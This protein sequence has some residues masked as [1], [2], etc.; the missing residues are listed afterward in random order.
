MAVAAAGRAALAL[1]ALAFYLAGYAVTNLGAF[2]V[3]AEL[4]RARTLADY[5]GMATRHRWLALSLIICLLGLIGTPPTA[6]FVGKLTVFTAAVDA[7]LAWLAVVAVVQR[8][9]RRGGL[10]T[11]RRALGPRALGAGR[12]RGRA[13]RAATRTAGGVGNCLPQSDGRIRGLRTPRGAR[14]ALVPGGCRGP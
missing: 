5:R 13:F 14:R 1:P 4:P 8:L 9:L 10:A 3:V 2:A 6:V 7:G 12:V 11:A